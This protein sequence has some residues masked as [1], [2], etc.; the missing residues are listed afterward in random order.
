MGSTIADPGIGMN[1]E[2]IAR[3]LEPFGQVLSNDKIFNGGTG[4]GLPQTKL[5]VEAPGAGLQI[6]SEP[7]VGTIV[8][9]KFSKDEVVNLSSTFRSID[10]K[11]PG[12]NRRLCG[13]RSLIRCEPHRAGGKVALGAHVRNRPHLWR[14]PATCSH[15]GLIPCR[16]P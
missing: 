8:T 7:N 16:R 9:I 14:L 15:P 1:A 11:W 5:R 6:E 2:D 13:R 4:L 12:I 3:V 10:S